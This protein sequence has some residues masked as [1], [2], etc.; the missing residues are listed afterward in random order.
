[1]SLSD[2]GLAFFGRTVDGNED[3]NIENQLSIT[4]VFPDSSLPEPTTGGFANQDEFRKFVTEKQ[5]DGQWD[6]ALHARPLA[7][8]LA[9]YKDDTI[10]MAFPLQFPFGH[11]GLPEDP[12][13]KKLAHGKKWKKHLKRNREDVLRRYLQ[14]RKPEFHT[15][16]FN[17]IVQ[18]TLLKAEAFRSTKIY[19][20]VKCGDG[21]SMSQRWVFT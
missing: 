16:L 19:C 4:V 7:D 17:L 9:D 3:V 13:V 8:R 11:T 14:L 20:N 18:S 12:A 21:D 5:K 1:M 10:A 2:I 6:S 15:S